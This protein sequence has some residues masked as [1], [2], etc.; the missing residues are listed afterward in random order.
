MDNFKIHFFSYFFFIK[1]TQI[2]EQIISYELNYFLTK[3][4]TTIFND[5]LFNN[6]KNRKLFLLLNTK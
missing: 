5:L 2:I 4:P 6:E 1:I 3:K